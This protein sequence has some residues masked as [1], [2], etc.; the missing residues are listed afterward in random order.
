MKKSTLINTDMLESFVY[1]EVYTTTML[2]G[3]DLVGEPAVNVNKGTLKP[4]TRLNGNRHEEA[5]IYYILDC[6]QG[7]EVVTGTGQEGD[8]EIRRK[9]KA[10]DVVF[11]PGG[12]HHWIDNREC[13]KPFSLIAIFSR[14][15]QNGLYHARKKEWGTAFKFVN[16]KE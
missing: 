5:E 9:V 2:M 10:G 1:D 7:A 11:I 12:V 3:E 15:E 4:H 14:Q 6:Q 16:S 8:K 13:D